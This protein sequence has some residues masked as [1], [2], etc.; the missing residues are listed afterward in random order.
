MSTGLETITN[1]L[2]SRDALEVIDDPTT[3]E[4]YESL[5]EKA[6]KAI[7]NLAGMMYSKVEKT[8]CI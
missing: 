5:K 8:T 2:F 3:D 4:L 6:N 7:E 1:D